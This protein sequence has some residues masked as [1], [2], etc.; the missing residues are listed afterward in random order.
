MEERE[1]FRVVVSSSDQAV[2]IS[3]NTSLVSIEDANF[4]ESTGEGAVVDSV[5]PQER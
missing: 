5:Y 1:A 2:R 4:G 3:S